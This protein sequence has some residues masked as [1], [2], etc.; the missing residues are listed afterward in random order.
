MLL[1]VI[2]LSILFGMARGGRPDLSM[3]LRMP[4]LILVAFSIQLVSIWL[5]RAWSPALILLS[6]LVLLGVLALNLNRQ[7]LRFFWVGVLLNL[8]VIGVNGGRMPVSLE[9]AERV[10]MQTTSLVAGTD[11]KRIALSPETPLAVLS[12]VIFLPFPIPRVVS[13]GD[14]L[15]AVGAFLL[16]QEYL[17]RPIS[18]RVRKL[19]L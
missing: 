16:V 2:L 14:V 4:W 17:S 19:S 5:P 1:D 6:Y 3:T 15:I 18:L 13:I 9:A 7:S 11:F 8:L 10:G 12:D